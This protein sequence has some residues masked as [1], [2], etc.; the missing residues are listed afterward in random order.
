MGAL[1][2]DRKKRKKDKNDGYIKKNC[3]FK[4]EK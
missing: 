1:D 2:F 4:V 3:I